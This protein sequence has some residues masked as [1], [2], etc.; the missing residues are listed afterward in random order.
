M[1]NLS[2]LSTLTPEQRKALVRR[3][4][5]RVRERVLHSDIQGR[6]ERTRGEQKGTC[7]P[8]LDK[9]NLTR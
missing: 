9:I 5:E 8:S 3:V 7:P 6:R 1:A 4:A 2:G